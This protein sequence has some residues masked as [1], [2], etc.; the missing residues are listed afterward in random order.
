MTTKKLEE[1]LQRGGFLLVNGLITTA[2]NPAKLI[3]FCKFKVWE[4][5]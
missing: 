2:N 5:E 3:T 1:L 4:Y